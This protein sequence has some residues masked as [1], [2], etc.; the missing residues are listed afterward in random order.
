MTLGFLG[1]GKMAEALISAMV[2]TRQIKPDAII[3]C[4]RLAARR[5]HLRRTYGICV[6]EAASD[7]VEAADLLFLA[8][9]PQDLDAL[10]TQLAPC[11]TRRHLL[12]SIAAGKS[13]AGMQA[14]VGPGVRLCRV[15]PNLAVEVGEGMCVC[16]LGE[17]ARATD[18]RRVERLLGAA[19][20]VCFLPEAHFDWVTA[21]SGSGPAF[22]AWLLRA[23]ID[24]AI[25]GGLPREAAETLAVQTLTGT[26]RL[27]REGGW[28]PD[29]LIQA[30]ASPGGT[31]AA[32]LSVLD[33]SDARALLARTL[34]AAA[35]RSHELSS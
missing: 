19:G 33:G 14:R 31:T 26:A 11:L 29:T 22:V 13:L 6:H 7:V 15:M 25:A 5:E 2:R 32:G 23:G 9:K 4:D 35:R 3:A 18:H 10:L 24:A 12:V 21:V 17:S 34:D 28:Q 8:V 1:A 16:C 27:L 20:K 30:V